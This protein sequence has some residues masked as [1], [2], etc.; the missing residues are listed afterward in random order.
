VTAPSQLDAQANRRWLI[1]IGITLVFGIFGAVMAVLSYSNR[2]TESAPAGPAATVAPG[3]G[4]GP[5]PHGRAKGKK[6][7]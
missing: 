6:H 5:A 3:A 7:D 4:A 1:G 2:S